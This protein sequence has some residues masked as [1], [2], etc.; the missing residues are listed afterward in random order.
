M[1]DASTN[2]SSVGGSKNDSPPTG[3][4]VHDVFDGMSKEA[5]GYLASLSSE[6]MQASRAGDADELR[7]I[8]DATNEFVKEERRIQASRATTAGADTTRPPTGPDDQNTQDRQGT[9]DASRAERPPTTPN[10]R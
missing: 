6:S 7:R 8:N 1:P 9:R 2:P 10:Q 3:L 5:K 4:S